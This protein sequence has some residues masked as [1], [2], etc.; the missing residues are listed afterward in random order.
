MLS[1]QR[2]IAVADLAV[3][4]GKKV[5]ADMKKHHEVVLAACDRRIDEANASTVTM[6]T[7]F[8]EVEA[9][10]KKHNS[11]VEVANTHA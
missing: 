8:A 11:E 5:V 10:V 9:D 2:R 4:A 1:Y 3:A 6:L 7:C